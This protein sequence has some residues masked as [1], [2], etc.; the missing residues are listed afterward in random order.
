MALHG[1]RDD[2]RIEDM[3]WGWYKY[4]GLY[5]IEWSDFYDLREQFLLF[6]DNYNSN[7]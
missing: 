4:K 1:S 7:I 3:F 2:V 6:A 5:L